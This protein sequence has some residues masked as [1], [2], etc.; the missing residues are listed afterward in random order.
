MYRYGWAGALLGV[1]ALFLLGCDGGGDSGPTLVTN[2]QN[3]TRA[4]GGTVTA[5]TAS[6]NFPANALSQ[7]AAVTLTQNPTLPAGAQTG[8]LVT[9][10]QVTATTG[11]TLTN[12]S[13]VVIT[14]PSTRTN[15]FPL[16]A[17]RVADNGALTEVQTNASQNGQQ[18]TIAI[19]EFGTFALY[20][21]TQGGVPQTPQAVVTSLTA[22]GTTALVGDVRLRVKNLLDP[23][24]QVTVKV[25]E[26][27][28]PTA[29]IAFIDANAP[30]SPATGG[31]IDFRVPTGLA[32][33]QQNIVVT[34]GGVTLA[35]FAVNVTNTNPHAVFT[36]ANGNKFVAEL[37]RDVAPNTVDNFT[38]LATGTKTWTP[39]YRTVENNQIVEKTIGPAQNGLFYDGTKFHRVENLNTTAPNTKII[40][41]GDPITKVANPPADWT[42]GTGFPGFS[43]NYETNNLTHEDGAVAMARGNSRDSASSQF[44]ICDGPQPA[45][46]GNYVVFGKVIEGLDKVRTIT[47]GTVIDEVLITGRLATPE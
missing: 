15:T 41:G 28:S 14:L 22:N 18:A 39:T 9:S 6:I 43:I 10:V 24:A 31:A 4:A 1:L 33:G 42:A 25:G 45:L 19:T 29:F 23:N 26:K 20:N 36:L 37:R 27:T 8:G 2:T 44:Y 38:G 34:V 47:V 13:N 7:D 3:L 46:N 35:P 17:Y 16:Y 40:Q 21:A 5:G 32:A 30:D 12:G 11:T